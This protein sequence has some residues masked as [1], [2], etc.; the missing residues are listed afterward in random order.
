MKGKVLIYAE[1]AEDW[2]AW[3]RGVMFMYFHIFV[4]TNTEDKYM[5]I[6][7]LLTCQSYAVTDALKLCT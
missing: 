5:N 6:T 2:Q 1:T 3:G 4:F 7:P